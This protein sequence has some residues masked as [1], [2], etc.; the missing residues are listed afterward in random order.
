MLLCGK[1]GVPFDRLRLAHLVQQDDLDSS[2]AAG[3]IQW[4]SDLAPVLRRSS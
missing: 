1:G 3:I 4:T 2:L